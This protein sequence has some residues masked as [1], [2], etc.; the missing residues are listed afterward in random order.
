MLT[1]IID[2]FYSKLT[3]PHN[4]MIYIIT[5]ASMKLFLVSNNMSFLLNSEFIEKYY[6]LFTFS[7]RWN[8][9]ISVVLTFS[10]QK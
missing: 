10:I 9:D 8:C 1:I 7:R 2:V 6:N 5:Y 3:C 4:V